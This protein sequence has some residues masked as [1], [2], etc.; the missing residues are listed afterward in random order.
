MD[1]MYLNAMPYAE[2]W[3]HCYEKEKGN[4]E[5]LKPDFV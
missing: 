5:F 1:K 2:F 3:G 4:I